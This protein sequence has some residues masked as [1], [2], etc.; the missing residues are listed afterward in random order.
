MKSRLLAGL[1]AVVAVSFSGG[2][3]S[4]VTTGGDVPAVAAAAPAPAETAPQPPARE[5]F[6]VASGPLVV[7]NQVDVAVQRDGIIAKILADTGT[8]VSKGQLLAQLDDRQLRADRDAAAAK[9]RSIEADVKNWEAEGGVR[10][11]DLRRS[12]E[13]MKANLITQQQLEHDRYRVVATRYEIDRERENFKQ[14]QSV[15]KS[16]DYELEKTHVVAPFSGV[17]A[18]RYVREGQRVANGDRIFWVSATAPLR[19]KFTLPERFLGAVKRGDRVPVAAAGTKVMHEAR[20][21]QVSPIVDPASGTIEVL[22]ELAGKP[23]DLQPGMTADIR[24][25]NPQ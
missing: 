21:I 15:L 16:L 22:A 5:E 2:C 12:E 9:M 24:I 8:H 1:V 11:T 4:S 17:V 7:E 10:E 18:R 19:V 25:K 13:M 20:V 6:F 3:S 23:A 14:Q